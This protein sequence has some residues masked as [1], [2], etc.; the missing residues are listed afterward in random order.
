MPGDLTPSKFSRNS[1]PSSWRDYEY[2]SFSPWK[3]D[4][5]WSPLAGFRREIHRLF[6]DFFNTPAFSGYDYGQPQVGAYWPTVDIKEK[7]DEVIVTAEVPGMTENEVELYFDKGVLTIRGFKKAEKDEPSYS[8]RFY[9]RFE[10]RIALPYSVDAEHCSAESRDGL[11]LVKFEKLA[12]ADNKK[13]IPISA[14]TTGKTRQPGKQD[15][16]ERRKEFVG[17]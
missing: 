4:Y 13:K 17:A 11:L 14:A 3:R 6:D 7:D 8:E 5:E 10:R 15:E 16:V 2:G 1:S 12:A 9:G